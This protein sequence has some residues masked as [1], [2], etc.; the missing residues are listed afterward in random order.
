M[1]KMTKQLFFLAVV[2]AET[3]TE[4]HVNDV[5][6]FVD[7]QPVFDTVAIGLEQELA[8]RDIVVDTAAIQPS[9]ILIDQALRI[10]EMID[11]DDRCNIVS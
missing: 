1:K 11:R 2:I 10:F 6:L 9:S 8:V 7:G 3:Q 4:G 5:I